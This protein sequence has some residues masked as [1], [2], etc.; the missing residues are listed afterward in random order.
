M[1]R[2]STILPVCS[3]GRVIGFWKP[4]GLGWE[5]SC[6]VLVG[7]GSLAPVLLEEDASTSKR[8]LPAIVRDSFCCRRQAALLSLRNSLSGSSSGLVN[9]LTMLRVIVIDL[10]NR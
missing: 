7:V 9:L 5:C 8:F 6:R 1:S 10:Q 2:E 3:V 4:K